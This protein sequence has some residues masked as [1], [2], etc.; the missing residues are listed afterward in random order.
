MHSP[1]PPIDLLLQTLQNDADL[2]A[3]LFA[4]DDAAEF[5]NA[6]SRLAERI[7]APADQDAL[8]QAMQAGRRAWFERNVP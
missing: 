4:M 8:R 6:V 5:L 1:Q 7:G 2:H 3:R